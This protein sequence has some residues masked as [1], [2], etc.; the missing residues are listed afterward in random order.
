MG[1]KWPPRPIKDFRIASV[2]S[3][4]DI[5]AK[6]RQ[7]GF[8]EIEYEVIRRRFWQLLSFLTRQGYRPGQDEISEQDI[9]LSTKLMN[10]DLND[11]G[12]L[13]VQRFLDKWHDRLYKDKGPEAE[14]KFLE[15]WHGQLLAERLKA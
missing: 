14:W 6:H 15:K 2:Q 5:E 1:K 11:E 13:F 9:C 12:Y 3:M 8:P 10:H 4:V 7:A